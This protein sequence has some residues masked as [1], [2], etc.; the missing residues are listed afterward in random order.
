MNQQKTSV[1]STRKT[2][3]S[4]TDKWWCNGKTSKEETNLINVKSKRT[5]VEGEVENAVEGDVEGRNI[6]YDW[7]T[8]AAEELGLVIR[9]IGKLVKKVN[10]KLINCEYVKSTLPTGHIVFSLAMRASQ[11]NMQKYEIN[12]LEFGSRRSFQQN[13][14]L[15]NHQFDENLLKSTLDCFEQFLKWNWKLW[16]KSGKQLDESIDW[17]KISNAQMYN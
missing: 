9:L 5:C 6:V 12:L 17:P 1:L 8:D 7:L 2:L 10:H 3:T 16:T 14:H 11:A 4:S 13:S 15:I